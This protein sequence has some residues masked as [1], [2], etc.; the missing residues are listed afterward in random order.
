MRKT[1]AMRQ[2]APRAPAEAAFYFQQDHARSRVAKQTNFPT[3]KA[4]ARSLR[5]VSV[6]RAA[7][8]VAV[9][10]TPEFRCAASW[11]L[12]PRSYTDRGAGAG[13]ELS[14][15]K[16]AIATPDAEQGRLEPAGPLRKH[17]GKEEAARE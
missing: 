11:P 8:A 7:A 6:F 17:C 14:A 2:I 13:C 3:K 10:R 12:L 9:L 15:N 16:C 5:G 4:F 1:D